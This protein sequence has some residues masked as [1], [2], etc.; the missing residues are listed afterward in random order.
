MAIALLIYACLDGVEHHE[1]LC[2][3]V[4]INLSN[5][6]VNELGGIKTLPCNLDEAVNLAKNSDFLYTYM[7]KEIVDFYL[8]SKKHQYENYNKSEDKEGFERIYFL[9]L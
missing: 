1:Q 5:A 9:T 7:P 3:S 4:N 8:K 2:E 6:D